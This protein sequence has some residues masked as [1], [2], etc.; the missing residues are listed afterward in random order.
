MEEF[1]INNLL[2]KDTK[3]IEKGGHTKKKIGRP[4]SNAPIKNK[5]VSSYLTDEEKEL[6]DNKVKNM[7]DG[8]QAKLVRK[9]VLEYL[10][11]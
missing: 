6:F 11:K 7:E 2:S 9:A 8:S 4:K 5:R 3:T 10:N 1:N